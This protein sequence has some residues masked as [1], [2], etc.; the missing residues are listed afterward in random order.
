MKKIFVSAYACEPG[1]GSEIGVGWHWVIELAKY[2]EVWV[3]T[4]ESNRGTIVPWLE[5]HREYEQQ[6]LGSFL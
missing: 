4:R 5:Q 1:M 2:H 6:T 3:L